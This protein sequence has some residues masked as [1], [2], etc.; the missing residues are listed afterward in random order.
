MEDEF[1]QQFGIQLARRLSPG[2][3]FQTVQAI[4]LQTIREARDAGSVPEACARDRLPENGGQG[5]LFGHE[6]E[7]VFV[8]DCR[9]GLES[10]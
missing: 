1:L 8:H 7:I 5:T 3:P 9:Y 2:V 10:N 6:I 4:I